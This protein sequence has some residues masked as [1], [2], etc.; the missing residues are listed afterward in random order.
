MFSDGLRIF[1]MVV[2]LLATAGASGD[3]P[4]IARDTPRQS[5]TAGMYVAYA[6]DPAASELFIDRGEIDL[7]PKLVDS[8]LGTI[9]KLSKYPKPD[10]APRISRISRAQIEQTICRGPC[11]LRAWYLPEEGIFL[12]ESLRPETDLVHRSILLHELV[13]FVQDVNS[14]AASMDACHRWLYREQEAYELQNQYL[15]L[16]GNRGD[17]YPLVVSNLNW[18]AANRRAC[19]AWERGEQAF[20]VPSGDGASH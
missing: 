10:T 12:D 1:A 4:Q 14:E 3:E 11:T 18:L 19:K 20:S 7:M 13:H 2:G 16:I 9:S 5:Q 8:L 17:G 6:N 15:A